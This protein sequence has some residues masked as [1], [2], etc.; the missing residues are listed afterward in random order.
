MINSSPKRD[1]ITEYDFI[2]YLKKYLRPGQHIS[3][4]SFGPFDVAIEDSDGTITHCF[5]VK[6]IN[7]SYKREDDYIRQYEQILTI[8]KD[9]RKLLVPYYLVT[10]EDSSWKFFRAP[11]LTPTPIIDVLKQPK[12]EDKDSSKISNTAAMVFAVLLFIVFLFLAAPYGLSFWMCEGRPIVQLSPMVALLGVI[13]AIIPLLLIIIKKAKEIRL[14]FPLGKLYAV[15]KA[16]N[17]D[18]NK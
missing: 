12:K 2:E 3:K 13:S 1:N 4:S 11:E 15:L 16:N 9:G 18:S 10:R 14:D 7:S 8:T 5:E 6:V 17:S